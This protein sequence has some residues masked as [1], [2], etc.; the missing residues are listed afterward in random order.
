MTK[1][2]FSFHFP[3]LLNFEG[4]LLRISITEIKPLHLL[5]VPR[6]TAECMSFTRADHGMVLALHYIWM[7]LLLTVIV[8]NSKYFNQ[9]EE[10]PIW[11]WWA[12]KQTLIFFVVD[13]DSAA[14]V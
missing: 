1:P 4:L 5:L 2:I 11:V 9:N 14:V 13:V 3:P 6:T 7:I 8:F 10:Y 12:T